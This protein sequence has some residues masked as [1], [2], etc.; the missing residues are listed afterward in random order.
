[1]K[2]V[3]EE[4]GERILEK[5]REYAPNLTDDNI[6]GRYT[7]TPYE[8]VQHFPNM[9]NGDIFMGVFT[10]DQVMYNHFGYRTPIEGIYMAGSAAH[11]GGA[12]SGGAGYITARII[13]EDLGI[14]PWWTPVHIREKLEQLAAR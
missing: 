6:L 14:K 12:I 7:Y 1:V 13:A 9:R 4:L 3:K 2:E 5:W 8:C 11:P 10:A